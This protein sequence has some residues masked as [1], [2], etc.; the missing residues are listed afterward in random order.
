M[1]SE[2]CMLI[3]VGLGVSVVMQFTMFDTILPMTNT[4]HTN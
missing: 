1:E 4:T 2:E 3:V